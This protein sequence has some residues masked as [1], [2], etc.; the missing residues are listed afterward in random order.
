MT[1]TL[2]ELGYSYDALEPVIDAARW[3]FIIP[4]TTRPI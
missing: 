1:Y 4:S 3:K 2:P